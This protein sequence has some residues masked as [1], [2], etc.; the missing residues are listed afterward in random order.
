MI[1]RAGYPHATV[2]ESGTSARITGRDSRCN[3]FIAPYRTESSPPST[4]SFMKSTFVT[5]DSASR[6]SN[7]H[8]ATRTVHTG[9]STAGRRR[10]LLNSFLVLVGS[11]IARKRNSGGTCLGKEERVGEKQ[12][13]RPGLSGTPVLYFCEVKL[14]S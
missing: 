14:D 5:P 7:R 9:S 10:L 6:S 13:G 12:N 1:S 3:S 8:T 4:S 11:Q 2:R